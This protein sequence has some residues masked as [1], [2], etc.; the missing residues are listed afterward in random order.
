MTDERLP[1]PEELQTLADQVQ[2]AVAI[3]AANVCD[4]MQTDSQ[5]EPDPMAAILRDLARRHRVHTILLK[6]RLA[7]LMAAIE[8]ARH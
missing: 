5:F 6:A 1:T 4:L 3:E 7:G 2:V 8:Q